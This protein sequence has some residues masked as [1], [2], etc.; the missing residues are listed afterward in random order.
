MNRLRSYIAL[1]ALVCGIGGT[2]AIVPVA[3]A[4]KCGGVQTTFNFGC[5]TADPKAK[6]VQDNPIFK[7]LLTIINLLAAG[8]GIAVVGGII[9]GSILFT[10]SRDNAAQKQKAI[11]VISN[12]VIGLVLFIFMYAIV[13]FLV[14]GGVFA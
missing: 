4:V 6:K 5:G 3:S 2:F 14:P 12:A 7:A 13:N 8:V 10:A 11:S 9:Y 1:V